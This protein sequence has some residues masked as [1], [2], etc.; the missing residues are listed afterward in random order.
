M[1]VCMLNQAPEGRGRCDRRHGRVRL[2]EAQV[3]LGRVLDLSRSGM[4][5]RTTRHIKP[6]DPPMI[7][8]FR[9]LEGERLA[10]QCKVAW[11]ARHGMFKRHAGLEFQ[12]LD[13][14]QAARLAELARTAAS[15]STI[16]HSI[17]NRA[18]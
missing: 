18:G 11:V 13:D 16:Q 1:A 12:G 7:V 2:E 4:R 9:T 15:N 10:V 17:L 3:S 14:H 6:T 5:V 8:R